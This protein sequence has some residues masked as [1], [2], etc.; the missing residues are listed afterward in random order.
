MMERSKSFAGHRID[1]A[2]FNVGR[3]TARGSRNSLVVDLTAS[4]RWPILV[5]AIGPKGGIRS[6]LRSMFPQ[7]QGLFRLTKIEL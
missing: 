7:F 1:G 2:T 6:M 3:F 4:L 5:R